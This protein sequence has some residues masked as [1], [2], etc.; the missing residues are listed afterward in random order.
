MISLGPLG[1]PCKIV[2]YLVQA[3]SLFEPT[4]AGPG[5]DKAAGLDL[6]RATRFVILGVRGSAR[7]DS[8]L[9]DICC[10]L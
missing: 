4:D 7:A 8:V 10:V 3:D 2:S 5:A 9:L 6:A 1:G